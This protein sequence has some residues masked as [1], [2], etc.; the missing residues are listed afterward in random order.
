[1]RAVRVAISGARSL[2]QQA[3]NQI[4]DIFCRGEVSVREKVLGDGAPNA[5]AADALDGVKVN[6]DDAIFE[7]GGEDASLVGGEG[8]PGARGGDERG[9]P[10]GATNLEDV[11][12]KGVDLGEGDV[13]DGATAGGEGVE[14]A[15][16]SVGVGDGFGAH[17]GD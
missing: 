10:V 2:E 15:S 14:D 16:A 4:M 8:A 3:I 7:R 17:D 5:A 6:E 13:N 11:A 9:R 1:V 12:A